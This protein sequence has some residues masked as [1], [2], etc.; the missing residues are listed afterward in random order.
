MFEH[1]FK[2][3]IAT[4]SEEKAFIEDF[5]HEL[6]RNYSKYGRHYHTLNHLDNLISELTLVKESI[7]DWQLLVFSI[8]YHDAI[9]NPLKNDNEDRS[10]KL[11]YSRLS[12]LRIS[13]TRRKKCT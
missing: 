9:Y 6:K 7:S 3:Q 11:A 4:V 8:A 5:W 10:A 2:N 13:E 1:L 12:Q